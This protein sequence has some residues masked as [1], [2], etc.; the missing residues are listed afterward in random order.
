MIVNR[1]G[2]HSDDKNSIITK[3]PEDTKEK[4]KTNN[5]DIEY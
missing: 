1:C 2:I 4:S 5:D 3:K